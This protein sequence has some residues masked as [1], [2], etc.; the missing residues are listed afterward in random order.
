[1][2]RNW[3]IVVLAAT[4][5]LSGACDKGPLSPSSNVILTANPTSV[6]VGESVTLTWSASGATS[7]CEAF[8]DWAG[9]KP[10]SGSEE[11][12]PFTVARRHS[13]SLRCDGG[14]AQV[15]IM[16]SLP[17]ESTIKAVGVDPPCG[18]S[19]RPQRRIA[20]VVDYNIVGSVD[21]E[22]AVT[23]FVSVDGVTVAPS[24]TKGSLLISNASG[25]VTTS[26]GLSIFDTLYLV[27]Q[28]TVIQRN[29]FQ[30]LRV[31]TAEV[32][33]CVFKP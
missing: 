32:K 12:G 5:T 26:V 31:L 8:G 33:P 20:V 27:S 13:F 19:I 14:N 1:M 23:T 4:S 22:V 11:V 18:S 24:A 6:M 28:L 25:T 30:I 15:T 21:G 9:P 29:P 7:S 16:V 3:F 10:I 2:F 17:A